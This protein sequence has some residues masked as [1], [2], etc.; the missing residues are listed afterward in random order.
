MQVLP[1]HARQW[2]RHSRSHLSLLVQLWPGSEV[3]FRADS[4]N[5]IKAALPTNVM[6]ITFQH[7][8]YELKRSYL[9]R[10]GHQYAAN[11]DSDLS[12]PVSIDLEAVLG[13]KIVKCEEKTL[14]GNRDLESWES[15]K[16]NWTRRAS[17]VKSQ[18]KCSEGHCTMEL[19]PMQI[20]T[21]QV[22][23]E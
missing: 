4:F 23:L 20:R 10:F 14:S 2:T 8:K 15:V 19:K 7:L 9:I 21:F 16:L 1:L 11:E 22:Q 5:L 6:L 12:K 13:C 18:V 3:P 17:P